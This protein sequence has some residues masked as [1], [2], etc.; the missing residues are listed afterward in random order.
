MELACIFTD[1]MVLQAN[2]TIRVFG[3]GDGEVSVSFMG[4]QYITHSS[5]NKWCVSIPPQEYGGPYDM[6]VDLDGEVKTISDI[7]VGEVW[8]ACGQSNMEFPLYKSVGGIDYAE[9]CDDDNIRFFTVSRRREKTTPE[10]GDH[11]GLT[12]AEDLPWQCC[13]KETA[14]TFS[15]IGF[16]VAKELRKKLGVA[17]GII[18][19]N[20]GGSMIEAHIKREYFN[21]T[22][23]LKAIIDEYNKVE[24]DAEKKLAEWKEYISK[25]NEALL[26][27]FSDFD[28]VQLVRDIGV[29]AAVERNLS[30]PLTMTHMDEIP[31]KW[32]SPGVLFDGM[33]SRITPYTVKGMMWYQ[34]ES[35]RW[36]G[37]LDKYLVFMDCMRTEFRNPDMPIYAVE[38]ASYNNWAVDEECQP[39]DHRFIT[40]DLPCN[41]AFNREQQQ[42]AT[43]IAVNNYLVTS[44]ELGD[45]YDIHPIHKKELADRMSKKMLKHTYNFD[46]AADQPTFKSVTFEK[47]KAII[48]LDNAEGLYCRDLSLVKMYVSDQSHELKRARIEIDGT[49]LILHCEEVENPILVRYGFDFYYDGMHIY[50]D[51]GL[52]LAPFRTDVN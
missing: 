17:V 21:K 37:Y 22:E 42:R 6:T 4:K 3:T 27:S 47:N 41:F 38:L 35:N 33:Y 7:M 1:H 8:L 32:Q 43:E 9:N 52:P 2:E 28:T 13:R 46:I 39:H 29:R 44:M 20:W 25:L 16:H 24:Y 51:S 34:G 48:E 5:E 31:Y 23:C 45:I 26:D 50:N 49:R 40:E 19:C 15:A 10:Y 36:E 30:K 11:F 18:S 12:P 14:L